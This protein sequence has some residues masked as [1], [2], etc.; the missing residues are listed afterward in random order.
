[1]KKRREYKA[2]IK[3]KDEYLNL[4]IKRSVIRT[5]YFTESIYY[6]V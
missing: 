3:Y 4:S 5:F 1:M 2:A 6:S